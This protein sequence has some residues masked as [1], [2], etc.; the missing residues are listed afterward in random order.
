MT[1]APDVTVVVCSFNGAATLGACID[2]LDG[3]T[4]RD[5]A[6]VLVVDDGSRDGTAAVAARRDVE[7]V[8]HGVNRGLAAARNTGWRRAR[9]PIVAFTD[10]DCVPRER[11]LEELVSGYGRHEVVAVGGPARAARADHL[12]HRYL[13][14]NNPLAPL[15]LDLAVSAS[16]PYRL[17]RYLARSPRDGERAVYALAGANLSVRRE[18]L[19]RVGGFDE[20]MR[21]AGEDEDL[22]RRVRLQ[23]PDGVLLYR[24]SAVVDHEFASS[25]ADTLR[26]ARAYGRG[27]G[28][29]FA[30]GLQG[31]IVYPFP[32]LVSGLAIAGLAAGRARLVSAAAVAPVLL[33]PRWAAA[34]ARSRSAE[35]LAY[36]YIQLLQEAA[37]TVGF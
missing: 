34:A 27:C 23:Y 29:G 36:G 16:V 7:L 25:L 37:G 15:E 3:Q 9:A 8:V 13:A 17:W 26:R 18:V 12:L 28:R 24:P 1:R 32:V 11:W 6:Q 21:F 10:D 4:M 31:P 20:R 14:A 19:E 35:P 33:F 30:L 2:A 22:C 5:R